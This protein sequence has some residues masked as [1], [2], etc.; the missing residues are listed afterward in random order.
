MKNIKEYFK[1]KFYTFTGDPKLVAKSFALG[2]FIGVSPLI[3]MQI[4]LSL[5][6]SSIFHLS[7]TASVAGVISTNWSKGL[8]LY[9][10]NFKIGAWLLGITCTVNIK[11]L[12]HGNILKNLVNIGVDVFL[13]LLVGGIVTGIF[14]AIIYY[15]I[16]ITILKNK[17]IKNAEL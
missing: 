14:I 17:S 9:P 6:I 11:A 2:S 12:F 16:I 10:L 5:L 8:F 15:F 13:A 1:E 7:K 4:I 3:G